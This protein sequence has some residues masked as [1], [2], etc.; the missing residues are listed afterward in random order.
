MLFNLEI[1]LDCFD[2]IFGLL[3]Y[4]LFEQT[5]V[6]YKLV[7]FLSSSKELRKFFLSLALSQALDTDKMERRPNFQNVCS[8]QNTRLCTECR[9]QY[10]QL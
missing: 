5:A 1:S 3:Y 9:K 7:P 4:L 8:L 10:S 6:S 2:I